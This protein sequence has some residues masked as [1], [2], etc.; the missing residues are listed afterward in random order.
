M[1]VGLDAPVVVV[2]REG[3]VEVEEAG[4]PATHVSVGEEVAFAYAEGAQ[5]GEGVV[6]AGAVNVGGRG[7]VVFG[8]EVV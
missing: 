8:D 1:D 6:V 5:V 2:G 7:P 3:G 4:V